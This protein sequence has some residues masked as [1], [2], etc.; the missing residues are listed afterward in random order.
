MIQARRKQRKPQDFESKPSSRSSCRRL[1][2]SSDYATLDST[3]HA[4]YTRTFIDEA[5]GLVGFAGFAIEI[6]A[7]R[8]LESHKQSGKSGLLKEGLGIS[9]DIPSEHILRSRFG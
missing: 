5:M 8:Q 2:S 3:V 6:A 7:D 9:L 1:L 4:R